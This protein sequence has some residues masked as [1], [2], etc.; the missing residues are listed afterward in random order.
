[1]P[2]TTHSNANLQSDC[3][4]CLEAATGDIR[5]L[6]CGHQFH[7]RCYNNWAQ[8][9]IG[10]VTCPNCRA[11]TSDEN[12]NNPR[13]PFNFAQH[14]QHNHV[15]YGMHRGSFD[16]PMHRLNSTRDMSPAEVIIMSVVLIIAVIGMSIFTSISS[17]CM[18]RL[19]W[20][21]GQTDMIEK[22]FWGGQSVYTRPDM[23]TY[24]C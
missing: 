12:G 18:C 10:D 17:T 2:C 21:P 19:H 22:N 23:C 14:L 24:V 1:M 16:I 5:Q 6:D 11:S 4:I 20:N 3:S 15:P 13:D 7:T 8:R 9:C